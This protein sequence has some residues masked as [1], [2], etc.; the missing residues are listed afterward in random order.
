M[1]PNTNNLTGGESS[2]SSN[3]NINNNNTGESIPNSIANDNAEKSTNTTITSNMAK[4]PT[5]PTS[6]GVTNSST[7]FE[8]VNN[9]TLY[10]GEENEL[11]RP[12]TMDSQN[13]RTLSS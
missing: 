3:S 4:C 1:A 8:I 6:L 13:F 2:S 5:S 12:E 11:D 10:L 9:K 7:S